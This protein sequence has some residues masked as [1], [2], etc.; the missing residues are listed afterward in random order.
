MV[1]SHILGGLGNQM[2]QYAAGRALCLAAEQPLLL[3]LRDFASYEL[4]Q[5]FELERVF[6]I[7]V[8]AATAGDVTKVLGWRA[9]DLVRKVLKRTQSSLLRGRHLA[10]EPHF[11]YWAGLRAV[12]GPRYLM[13]YWQSEMYFKDYAEVLRTDFHFKIPLDNISHDI[14]ERMRTSNAVS[15][16]V[17]RGDYLSHAP[18]AK[19]LNVCSLDYYRQ[20][21]AY[22]AERVESPH[23]FLF[24]DDMEWV[25][26]G[27]DIPFAKTYVEHNR[28][29]DSYRD[30][31]LMH[32]CRHH[33][34]ANSSFSWWGAWLNPSID[35]IVIAPKIWFTDGKNDSDLIPCGWVRL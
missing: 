7:P 22:I 9:P 32:M 4:H 1:I 25:K 23:F 10:I 13:G 20:A 12:E 21:I 14:A 19:I 3:D 6:A 8:K 35:K 34:I 27:L 28:G 31:Q 11:K 15:L 24:S 18:T 30:M 2:F 17:R 16:H 29:Y 5:G 33:V 26:A